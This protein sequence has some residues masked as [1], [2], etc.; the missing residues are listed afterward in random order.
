MIVNY[1]KTAIRHLLKS[2][3]SFLINI[4]GLGMG[5]VCCLLIFL[6]IQY[7]TSFDR[8]HANAQ[9]IYRVQLVSHEKGYHMPNGPGPLAP[10]LKET[11]PEIMN[12]ARLFPNA[13][14][15]LQCGDKNFHTM[16]CGVE[17]S[18]LEIFSFPF[19]KGDISTAFSDP[20]FIILTEETAKKY[21]GDEDPMGKIMHFEWWSRW[22]EFHVMGVIQDVPTNSHL[23]FDALIPFSFVTASGMSIDGWSNQC[24]HAYVQ[25]DKHADLT[26][27]QE[28]IAGA[29]RQH[30]PD[31]REEIV[32]EPLTRI[33]L[34]DFTGGGPIRMIYIFGAIGTFML[35]IACIN[36]MN[37]STVRTL[38]RAREVSMRKIAGSSRGQLFLQFLGETVLMIAIAL[39]T[40][41][42]LTWLFLPTLNHLLNTRIVMQFSSKLLIMLL[43]I[44]FVTGLLAGLFPAF[45]LSSFQ[46]IQILRI[47]SNP[48]VGLLRFQKV[49]IVTQFI[50]SS[51]LIIC[52]LFAF[53]QLNFIKDMD[54]GF[55]KNHIINIPMGGSMYDQYDMIKREL[56]SN[57]EILTIGR[58]NFSF[59][60]RFGT[61][62]RW[63][64]KKDNENVSLSIWSVDFNFQQVFNVKMVEGRF[65]SEEFQN[66]IFHSFIVNEMA[67][68]LMELESPVGTQISCDIPYA[69]G[70]GT[71]IGVVKNFHDRSLHKKIQPLILMIHPSWY[72][73]AYL[74]IRPENISGTLAFIERKLKAMVPEFPIEMKFFDEEVD[75][76][77][78]TEKRAG[79][80]FR[81]GAITTLF[82]ACMGLFGIA[83]FTMQQRTKEI[84]IRKIV[85]ASA[86]SIFLNL[87]GG[88][89]KSIVW[90]NIIA[91]P[92][93]YFAMNQWLQNFAYRIQL[94]I[95]IFIFSGLSAVGITLLTVSCQTIKAATANPV[96]ALRYE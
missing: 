95:W 91:C 62:L 88:F 5:M 49:M 77:Y 48:K 38:S 21:F 90:A 20:N 71:I 28:K 63:E 73:D 34:H 58:S 81:A 51:L 32:L 50:I 40:A 36:F 94:S 53:Q 13:R 89:I 19:V 55:E 87:S 26:S 10:A 76:L 3:M 47:R 74:R 57:P 33:H 96:E 42:I 69:D 75:R 37:L 64:G 85:G 46:H 54:L 93:A 44:V 65:F 6:W 9:Q 41:T 80:L 25:V 56:E 15:P 92:I 27:L 16:V 79:F 84:G 23:Q 12:A 82:I 45:Y 67:A 18:F 30:Y 14:R 22:L 7:E 17:S 61:S 43:G 29:Y 86:S 8:F 72:T 59:R 2:R 78:Q 35:L 39:G 66:D 70:Y 31:A 52:T 4:T 60:S 24:Y 83:S 1:T 68:K 11:Y